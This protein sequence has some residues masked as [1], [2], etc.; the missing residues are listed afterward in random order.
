MPT[1]AIVGCAHIHIPGFIQRI[2]AR[3]DVTV[4]SVWDHQRARAEKRAAEVNAAIASDV[5]EIWRDEE[6][7]AVVICSE[8]NRHESLVIAAAGAKKHLFVEKPLGLAAADAYKMA[9]AI[10]EAGLIFTTG[11]FMRGDPVHQ[12]LKTHLERGSFGTVTRIH[13]TDCHNGGLSGFFDDEWAWMADLEQAGMGGFGDLGT[14]SLDIL[15]WLMG[16]VDSVTANL[17]AVTGRYGKTDEFGEGL[18][19]FSNGVTGVLSA[20]WVHDGPRVTGLVSGLEGNAHFADGKL[21]FKSPHVAGADGQ[22]EWTDLPPRLPHQ[23]E[24]FFDALNGDDAPLVTP[25]EAARCCAV[26]EAFYKGAAEDRWVA[27]ERG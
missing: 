20:S 21:Y 12:F 11:Y 27:P 1:I 4:K 13:H 9:R 5:S 6:I 25:A 3:D 18:M 7:D 14:H 10:E 23:F 2:N 26:M 24:M 19:R 22:T 8:T 15:L 16:D 17:G